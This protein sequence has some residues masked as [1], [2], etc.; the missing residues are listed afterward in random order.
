MK[1]ASRACLVLV[2][3]SAALGCQTM[4][5]VVGAH[6]VHDGT[7]VVY[8][9]PPAAAMAIAVEVLHDEG[10]AQLEVHASEGYVLASFDMN[11]LSWGTEAGVWV[12]PA[13]P[14]AS[15]VT[16]VT[17]RRVAINAVTILTEDGFHRDFALAV[18]KARTD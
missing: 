17:K 2:V 15:R 1:L 5:D 11:G 18:G 13:G 16:V 12:E 4:G 9:V 14:Q 7:S 8:D 3:S 10:N 6:Q